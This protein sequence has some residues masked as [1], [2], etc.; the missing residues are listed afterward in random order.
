[1]A[2]YATTEQEYYCDKCDRYCTEEQMVWPSGA[3]TG[4]CPGCEETTWTRFI[5][6]GDCNPQDRIVFDMESLGPSYYLQRMQ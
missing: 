5:S 4:R 1:M 6:L 2:K 3:F